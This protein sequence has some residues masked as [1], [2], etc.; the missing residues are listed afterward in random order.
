LEIV[1]FREIPNGGIILYTNNKKRK[2]EI[3]MMMEDF[4][5]LTGWVLGRFKRID[6]KEIQSKDNKIFKE[7]KDEFYKKGNYLKREKAR[8]TVKILNIL[9]IICAIWTL[10]LPCLYELAFAI[11][12]AF[13]IVGLQLVLRYKGAIYFDK[14][15]SGIRPSVGLIIIIPSTTMVLRALLDY[16]IIYS[17][18]FWVYLAALSL[19]FIGI[20]V[21]L[22]LKTK[23]YI[24]NKAVFV[25]LPIHLLLYSYGIILHTNCIT[26]KT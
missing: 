1:G 5:E 22:A 9:V 26:N 20:S 15:K 25:I 17:N 13:P 8:K 24:R 3:S 16:N 11:N 19:F 4:Y 10:F 14:N 6:V 23:E 21:L 7:S 12:A 2:I 18:I